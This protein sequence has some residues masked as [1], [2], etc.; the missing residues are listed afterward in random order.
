MGRVDL[1][2]DAE[3][4][5]DRRPKEPR[6]VCRRASSRAPWR[7]RSEVGIHAPASTQSLARPVTGAPGKSPGGPAA[8]ATPDAGVEASSGV[9]AA[10]LDGG[11]SAGTRGSK[12]NLAVRPYS[13]PRSSI[14]RVSVPAPNQPWKCGSVSH[15]IRRRPLCPAVRPIRLHNCEV[16]CGQRVALIGMEDRQY[17]QSFEAGAAS[18]L[19][20]SRLICRTNRKITKATMTKSRMALR[21]RP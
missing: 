1:P 12:L 14:R 10:T 13:F 7:G 9:F 6:A 18:G 3:G 19:R 5:R 17:G 21:N 4:A 11:Q 16:Q 20:V 15:T 8:A 2:R